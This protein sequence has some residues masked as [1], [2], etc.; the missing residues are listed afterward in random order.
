MSTIRKAE[1]TLRQS[2]GIIQA[3]L[4][5]AP[6]AMLVVDPSGKIVLANAQAETLFGYAHEELRGQPEEVLM[7]PRFHKWQMGSEK[8]LWGQRKDGTE[9]PVEISLSSLATELGPLVFS[10]I[11]DIT[12]QKQRE[13]EL[14]LSRHS[15]QAAL[16]VANLAAWGWDEV[17]QAKLWTA[18]TKAI[19][20]LPPEVEVTRPLFRSLLH[21]DDLPRYEQEWA[22][23][24]DPRGSH[25][26]D[27]EYRIRRTSDGAERW[28]RTRAAVEFEG[29]RLVRV[30]GALRDITE[31]RLADTALRI[32]EIRYRRLFETAHDGVL[33]LDP[34]T[35]K[36]TD[37]NPYMTTLLGYSHEQLVGKE[38]FEIGLL[39]DEEASQEMV[40]RLKETHLV[41]YEDLPLRSQGGRRQEVEVVANLYEE[42]GHPVIQCN[43][44]DITERKVAQEQ[45]E[46]LNLR[47]Q[48]AVAEAQH[49][50]KNNLQML[51]ALVELQLPA[52]GETVPISE[53][54]RIG[55]HIRTLAALHDLMSVDSPIRSGRDMVSLKAA[56]ETLVP[57]LQATSGGRIIHVFAEEM[58]TSLKQGSSF[59]LLV[60]ELVSNALKHGQGAITLALTRLPGPMAQL[61]VRDQG[62]GFPAGFDPRAAA[63]TG[64][65]LI[66]SMGRWDLRGEVSYENQPDN[67]AQITLTFPLPDQEEA[68]S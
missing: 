11:R 39:S 62:P 57:M 56:L 67:G 9:F 17:S 27:L 65:E 40:R 53:L 45:I 3:L 10:S 55:H 26:Y 28:I 19:F 1:E 36:I 23:A 13:T 12:E 44:R 60:N 58:T 49:R 21:P 5:A 47:L 4:E 16:D 20:G 52:T 64:L 51:S 24:I 50:I 30:M 29:D 37:A 46:N 48:R 59:T 38:L 66:E 61:T 33:L 68:L 22:R 34:E 31:E 2:D 35:R 18:Q 54:K 32:S 43:I 6:D 7:P 63:N 15:L 42:S 41:R 14:R 25:T 8:E